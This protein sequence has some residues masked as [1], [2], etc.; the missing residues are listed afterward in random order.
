MK[1]ARGEW[2]DHT[3]DAGLRVWAATLPDLLAGCAAHMMRYICPAGE[4]QSRTMRQVAVE[5]HDLV[6]LLVHWLNE[7]N[8][9]GS[10]HHELYMEFR[11]TLLDLEGTPPHHLEGVVRG[12]PIDPARHQPEREI[13]AVTYHAADVR[14]EGGGWRAQVI[15][16]I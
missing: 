3:G 8:A 9:L 16:D 7:I 4:I 6:E 14:K 11:I 1:T 13:K 12:E 5:G 10:L 15:F 2:L